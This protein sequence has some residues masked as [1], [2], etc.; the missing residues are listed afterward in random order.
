MAC[1]TIATEKRIIT[2][3]PQK[4]FEAVEVIISEYGAILL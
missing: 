2:I 1:T 4:T 3:S